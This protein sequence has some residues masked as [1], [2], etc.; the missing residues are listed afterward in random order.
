VIDRS[1]A[2]RLMCD[3][4]G[5]IMLIGLF[6]GVLLVAALYYVIGIGEAIAQRERMQ[7]A[8]DAAAF[9]TAVLHARGM[10]AIALVNMVMAALLATLI[11]L[12][13]VEVLCGIAI[14]LIAIAAFFLDPALVAAIPDIE[15]LRQQVRAAHDALEPEIENALDALHV[16]ARGIRVVVPVAAQARSIDLVAAHYAPPTE[17]GFAV[18]AQASLPTEDAPFSELCDRAGGYVGD[19]VEVALDAVVPHDIAD[20]V[21]DAAADLARAASDWYCA[22]DGDGASTSV[23]R[24]VRR[25]TLPA[26]AACIGYDATRADYSAAHHHDLCE[27]ARID[28]LASMPDAS[29]GKC[30]ERCD[31]DGPYAQRVQLARTECAPDAGRRFT[32]FSW[33]QRQVEQEYVFHHGRWRVTRMRVIPGT[34][35]RVKSPTSPCGNERGAI[36]TGWNLELYSDRSDRIQPVC[37]SRAAPTQRGFEGATSSPVRSLE[38]LD[39]LGC[40]EDVVLRRKVARDPKALRDDAEHARSPQRLTSDARL[41]AEAFQLRAYVL[42]AA[43][44]VDIE[45]ILEVASWN[46]VAE[47]PIAKQEREALANARRA[48]HSAFAQAEY[49]YAVQSDDPAEQASF[50][51]NMRWQARLR[52]FRLPEPAKTPVTDDA[53]GFGTSPVALDPAAACA[54]ARALTAA[55]PREPHGPMCPSDARD[56]A[57]LMIH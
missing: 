49:F 17:I 4:R 37:S 10:N 8:A 40:R 12:K 45:R 2:R 27:R 55:A 9:S 25:P 21:G 29:T 26:R 14:A 46:S 51:W 41:G 19:L 50:L 32:S 13:L 57:D 16:L 48:G 44:R 24:H 7:D 47:S 31:A 28:E 42:G 30:R 15:G 11:A 52:R 23:L 56:A 34:T 18:P 54:R 22:A 53:I 5:A 35:H 6:M 1:A 38:V 39:I 33:V 43:P 3:Q 20:G 36:G